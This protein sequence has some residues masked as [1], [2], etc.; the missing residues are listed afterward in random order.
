M[1]HVPVLRHR[2]FRL[3]FAGQAVSII[4]DS[5]FPIALAFAV[6]DDLGGSAGELG[7]VLAAQ[8]WSYDTQRRDV[9]V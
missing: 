1:R 7:L 5:L 4:G 8:G 2:D 9:W 6:L 3:L